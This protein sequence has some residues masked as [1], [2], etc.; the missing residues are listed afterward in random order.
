MPG[1]Y[2]V[3]EGGDGV[4]KTSQVRRLVSRLNDSGI[5]AEDVQEPGGDPLAK[6]IRGL[7]LD[8]QYVSEPKTDVLLFNAARVQALVAVKELLQTGTW[9]VSDRSYISTLA[10]QG[11]GSGLDLAELEPVC[12]YAMAETMPD[13]ILVL[14]CDPA[15]ALHRRIGRGQTDRIEAAGLAF[16]QRVTQ[17]F[18]TIA[19]E[20]GLPLIDASGTKEA[21][22]ELIWQQVQPLM[23]A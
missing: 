22:H 10:Y 5:L 4:G 16:H 21:V 8:S 17:G 7:L 19:R 12:R 2:I 6:A 14:W 13:L 3:L 15:V 1:R 11:Y 23:E 18:L 9:A 20:Q